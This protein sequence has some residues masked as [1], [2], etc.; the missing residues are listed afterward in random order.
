MPQNFM[1]Y[2]QSWSLLRNF[3]HFQAGR[4]Q[5]QTRAAE[6]NSGKNCNE[7]ARA[8]HYCK[9]SGKAG[10]RLLTPR[11]RYIQG[12]TCAYPLLVVSVGSG[13]MRSFRILFD[14]TSYYCFLA[15]SQ[16]LIWITR[17]S[18]RQRRHTTFANPHTTLTVNGTVSR[19]KRA[20]WRT[21]LRNL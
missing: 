20:R 13:P 10:E 11:A 17:R 9:Q 21:R 3:R 4:E 18:D 6:R 12:S 5:R 16:W 15:L 14:H 7:Y 1:I 2:H 8:Q 19:K